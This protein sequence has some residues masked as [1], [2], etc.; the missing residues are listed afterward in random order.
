[1]PLRLSAVQVNDYVLHRQRLTP[2]SRGKSVLAVVRDIGP[3][4]ASPT[5][6]PYI[7]LWSRIENFE[8]QQLE[9]ALYQERT[10]V[11]VPCMN[12]RLY[13]VPSADYPAYYQATK[14]FLKQGLRELDGLLSD[15]SP[16]GSVPLHSEDLAQRVLE[17]MSVW[18]ACTL[19]KLTELLPTLSTQLPH[20]PEQPEQGYTTLG[21]RLI[22]AMCAQGMLVR[23]QPRGSWRSDH[24]SYTPLS[25]WLPALDLNS[26]TER[27]ALRQVILSYVTAFGPVTVGDILHWLGGIARHKVV[28]ALMDLSSQLMRLQIAGSQGDYVMLREQVPK[29]LDYERPAER[30][31]GLLPPRDSYVAAYS[32][33]SRFLDESYREYVFDRAGEPLGTVW[34]DGCIVG[35]WWAQIKEERIMVRFFEPMDPEALA[36]IAEE[37]LRL[38]RFLEFASPDL[39]MGSYFEEDANVEGSLVPPL[40]VNPQP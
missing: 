8:R 38:G 17:I 15:A 25:S 4:R 6:T 11:R 7:S 29:L 30:M 39:Q 27:E 28:A 22:P 24:Y 21:A 18:G 33:T 16:K 10:L 13:V 26:V 37:A 40:Q 12:A 31:V 19:A 34:V 23:T 5:I 35:L 20:D 9:S 3:L 36:L 32:D 14:P 2:A 1:M